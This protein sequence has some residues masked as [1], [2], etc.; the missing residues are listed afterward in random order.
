M[1]HIRRTPVQVAQTYLGLC[2]VEE[3]V[4]LAHAILARHSEFP[5]PP[6]PGAGM[7][8]RLRKSSRAGGQLVRHGL[9]RLEA[10]LLGDAIG[11]VCL[12]GAIYGGMLIA[13]VLQ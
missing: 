12:M 8:A 7:T 10:S 3:R 1:D 2:S 11:C 6:P 9:A 5:A 4:A 13:G